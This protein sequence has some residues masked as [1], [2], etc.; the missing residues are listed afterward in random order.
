MS[1]RMTGLRPFLVFDFPRIASSSACC[2]QT[3]T[4][5]ARDRNKRRRSSPHRCPST[6]SS[7]AALSKRRHRRSRKRKRSRQTKL[8]RLSR[9]RSTTW[10]CAGSRRRH[11]RHWP[12]DLEGGHRGRTH[13][14]VA[15][16]RQVPEFRDVCGFPGCSPSKSVIRRLCCYLR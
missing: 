5:D 7:A 15:M 16:F 10:R 1:W 9:S 13:G 14:A 11:G 4:P 6:S 2:L 3:P 12:Q 8:R